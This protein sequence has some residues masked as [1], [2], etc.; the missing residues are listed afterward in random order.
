MIAI[1]LALMLAVVLAAA[2]SDVRTRRIPNAL[3]G[4]LAAAALAVHAPAGAA[5][6]FSA[7]AAM[8]AVFLA[9]VF[10]H[11]LRIFGGGDVKLLAGCCGIAGFPGL[12]SLVLYTFIAGGIVA[13]IDLWRRGRLR[14]LLYGVWRVASGIPAQ[15]HGGVPY[16]VAIA[17]GSGVYVLSITI[18][19]FMRLPL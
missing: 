10:A 5:S 12:I 14:P 7:G 17:M 15:A 8:L 4:A 3:T 9:G 16:G 13:A 2:Y 1:G 11:R 6:F 18:A 19:P